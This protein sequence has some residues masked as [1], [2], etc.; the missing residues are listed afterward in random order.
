MDCNKI[1]KLKINDVII[2]NAVLL[3]DNYKFTS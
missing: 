2:F 3:S 1:K